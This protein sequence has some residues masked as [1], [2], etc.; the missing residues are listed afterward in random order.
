MFV[1]EFSM[2]VCLSLQSSLILTGSGQVCD[3]VLLSRKVQM[4][5]EENLPFPWL[6]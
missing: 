6:Q 5:S 1:I 4:D 3:G 2:I